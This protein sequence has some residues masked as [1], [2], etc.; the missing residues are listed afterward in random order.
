MNEECDWKA[1]R[2]DRRAQLIA[3]RRA[4]DAG[5]R[6]ARN[7]AIDELLEAG[8]AAV[9]GFTVG[10]CWPFAAEP[11]PRFAVRRW[12]ESGSRCALP[13]VVAPRTPLEFRE[14]WPGVPM[15]AGVYDIPYPVG[16]EL[17]VPE[18]AVVPVNGFDG[19]GYRLGYGGGFF[20]RTLAALPWQPVCIGL[21]YEPAR[22]D[23]IGPRPHDVPFDFI[24]TEAGIEARMSGRL[25]A[26]SPG[27]ADDR[28]R[29][30]LDERLAPISAGAEPSG[31][32][33]D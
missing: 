31:Q 16:T 22:M 24:V 3:A 14:W 33:P 30:L 27:A 9:G 20:D 15:R 13:V 28:L 2:R 7:T 5:D 19:G 17:L 23:T 6:A 10:F 12:R 4:L 1:W 26:V 32:A 8:F 21:G 11:E 18:I 25:Q 29:S